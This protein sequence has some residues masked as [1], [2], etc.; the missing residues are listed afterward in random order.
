M[1]LP[2]AGPRIDNELPRRGSGLLSLNMSCNSI[3]GWQS[4]HGCSAARTNQ[5]LTRQRRRRSKCSTRQRRDV[6]STLE[7]SPGGRLMT[8]QASITGGMVLC[9]R[10]VVPPA[11]PPP[12]IAGTPRSDTNY[13]VGL[14]QTPAGLGERRGSH[15]YGLVTTWPYRYRR[16]SQWV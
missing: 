3:R 13:R 15:G 12:P 1:P 11:L 14:L 4:R 10:D 6:T 8:G 16:W 2:M 5:R 7:P 9:R